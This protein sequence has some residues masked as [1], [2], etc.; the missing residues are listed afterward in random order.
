MAFFLS[1]TGIS[2]PFAAADKEG[3]QHLL[4]MQPNQK[5]VLRQ[6]ERKREKRSRIATGALL[7]CLS[8]LSLL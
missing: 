2:L 5:L 6:S 8:S 3:H 4:M 7:F 1:T